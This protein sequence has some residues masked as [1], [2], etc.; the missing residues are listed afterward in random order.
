ML[1]LEDKLEQC[2]HVI[3]EEVIPRGIVGSSALLLGYAS[4][5]ILNYSPP[6]SYIGSAVGLFAAGIILYH[7]ICLDWR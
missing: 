6:I 7:A 5:K 1:K 3:S 4:I 2:K